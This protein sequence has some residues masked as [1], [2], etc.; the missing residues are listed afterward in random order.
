MFK[1]SVWKDVKKIL[2]LVTDHEASFKDILRLLNHYKDDESEFNKFNPLDR[3]TFAHLYE[4]A[5]I[6]S[7]IYDSPDDIYYDFLYFFFMNHLK[8]S[9]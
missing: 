8:P 4:Y 6:N 2:G 5:K 9:R 1:D 3:L 7:F